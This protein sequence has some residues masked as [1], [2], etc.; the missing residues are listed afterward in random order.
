VEWLNPGRVPLVLEDACKFVRR[1]VVLTD[2]QLVTVALWI[3]HTH[4]IQAAET[5]PYLAISS[6]EKKSGKSRLGLE[7][8]SLLV[9][10][11]LASMSISDAALFRA[12]EKL[13]PTLLLDEADAVFKAR[14]REELRGLLNSGYRRGA[15]AFRM[16][17]ASKT[18][19]ESFNVFSAKAFIGIGDFLPDT[20]ADRSI[21][22]RLKRKMRD[23][24]VDRFRSRDVRPE[25]EMLRDRLADWLQPQIDWLHNA[26]PDL[27]QEL[28]DRAQD[29]WEP[30]LA[31][32]ELAGGDWP[33]RARAAAIALSTGEA[34]ED[35]SMTALLLKDIRHVFETT[36]EDRLKTSVLI[37]ALCQIEESP[38]GDWYGKAISPQV[39][40]KLLRV[41]RIRTM[42]VWVDGQTVKGY[43]VEQF[44]D[45]F[46]RVLAVREVREVRSE[47]G[48]QAAPN[49]PNP[50][51]HNY[52][53]GGGPQAEPLLGDPG[54][55][56][57]VDRAYAEGHVT[58]TELSQLLAISSTSLRERDRN[59]KKEGEIRVG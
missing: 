52:S 5:T 21:L 3:A 45:A 25:G 31:I 46:A 2:E 29:M 56:V 30:L 43:K 17:G 28:D 26:R 16:G 36:G 44:A 11:P 34:R 50:P 59:P 19:L 53:N 54:Y 33:Q 14:E 51:N 49:P 41:H 6:A 35:D 20:L 42:P 7:V 32:A 38:W 10:E 58:V 48:S 12:I 9:H 23:E 40:S 27:P 39:L 15:V 47:A 24:T 57:R 22:I 55:A 4:A 8:F 13:K 37:D 1:F 18:T